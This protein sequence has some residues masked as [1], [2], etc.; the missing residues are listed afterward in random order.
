MRRDDSRRTN[1]AVGETSRRRIAVN[2]PRLYVPLLLTIALFGLY[3]FFSEIPLELP[4]LGDVRQIVFGQRLG[5]LLF[6]ALAALILLSVRLADTLIFDLI[7]SRRRN[8][9]APQLLRQIVSI[10]LYLLLFAGAIHAVFRISITTAVLTSTTVLAAVIGLAMQDTLGN[11]FAGISLHMEGSFEVGDVI[12]SGD[13]IGVVEGINWRATRMRTVNNSVIVLPNSHLA[14]DR[15]EVFSRSALNARLVTVSVSY[16]SPPSQ[17]ISVL[18]HAVGNVEGVSGEIKCL[19]RIGAFAESGVTYE[20]KYWTRSYHLRDS[21]DA[22]IRQVVW[23]ALK[24]NGMTIPYPIRVIQRMPREVEVMSSEDPR[25]LVDS[26]RQAD[27]LALLTEDEMET[28]AKGSVVRHFTRGE[29]ILR[30]GQVGESMFI[31]RSGTVAILVPND[32]ATASPI[33]QLHP[34]SV[35][36]EMALFTG[37]S[38]TADVVAVTDV[39]V[40]EV[41]K[42]PLQEIMFNNPGLAAAISSKI[43]ER[44]G[45]LEASKLAAM[46]NEETGI[47]KR[48]RSYF[49]I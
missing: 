10:V 19:G 25:R 33:A 37:E 8:F 24:R 7:V 5:Y 13:M 26:L 41:G 48:I 28:L 46:T 35:F 22:N 45:H 38:R 47:L 27:V 39:E 23:Y 49:G 18:E 1:S 12:R 11:L 9:V 40:V 42:D 31:I 30:F 14:K 32:D 2:R 16:D 44:Q 20:I 6:G 21:I 34:G 36:G 29:T 4:G 3:L 17:V 15:I 43:I